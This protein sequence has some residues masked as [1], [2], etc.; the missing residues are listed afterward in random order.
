MRSGVKEIVVVA[1]DTTRYGEDLYGK[2]ALPALLTSLSKIDGLEWIR[3]LYCYP[4]RI[5]DE[6]IDAVANNDKIVKYFD[7]PIQHASAPVLKRM[8]VW[9]IWTACFLLLKK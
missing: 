7:I 4:E 3:V 5:T 9:A 1:Q 8:N 6:L 2:S